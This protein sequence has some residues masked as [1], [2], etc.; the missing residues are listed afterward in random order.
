MN[1][2]TQIRL[3]PEIIKRGVRLFW[4]NYY[5]RPRELLLTAIFL[6]LLVG[7]GLVDGAKSWVNLIIIGLY[8]FFA[9][10]FWIVRFRIYFLLLKEKMNYHRQLAGGVT[11]LQLA[12]G[13]AI[14]TSGEMRSEFQWGELKRIIESNEFLLL[15]WS[16]LNFTIIPIDQLSQD[17]LSAI[18][19]KFAERILAPTILQEAAQ[20]RARVGRVILR[21]AYLW[22]IWE[23]CT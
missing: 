13:A 3:T 8:G 22:F 17:A 20:D 18:R 21:A 5:V 6:C 7:I 19:Q 14:L 4:K 15:W 9:L 2:E 16:R 10:W 11:K 1:V 23:V 12:D